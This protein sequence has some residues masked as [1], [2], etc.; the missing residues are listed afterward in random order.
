MPIDPQI[1]AE[2][3][4]LIIQLLREDAD[5]ALSAAN[6]KAKGKQ[7]AGTETDTQ[8]A[9]RLYLEDLQKAETSATDKRMSRSLQQAVT[10][11][12][13]AL[14]QSQRE[15]QIAQDG[16]GPSLTLGNGEG[17]D[18]ARAPSTE[19]HALEAPTDKI[20]ED[21]VKKLSYLDV[22]GPEGKYKIDESEN[23]DE[24]SVVGVQPESDAWA[25]SRP[26]KAILPMRQCTA[27]VEHFNELAQA[28]CEHEY[29]R[30]CLSRLFQDSMIDETLFPPQCCRIPI[31][32][33]ENR[34]LLRAEIAQQF[35]KKAL[36]FS[37]PNRTYCCNR[38]CAAFIP[39]VVG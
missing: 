25:T 37:T 34:A 24:E 12:S 35:P 5:G 30:E 14:L 38:D 19:Q 8:I 3:I 23:G 21:L 39:N 36:E 33:D 17:R 27:C 22:A 2:D 4:A 31:P 18:E 32:F 9:L 6:A 29:C 26:S 11:D 10:S 20:D 15:E 1:G 16:R 13:N 28:P 7:P